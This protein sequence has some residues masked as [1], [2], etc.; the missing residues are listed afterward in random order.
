MN[1]VEMEE[2][3]NVIIGGDSQPLHDGD[4]QPSSLLP[5]ITGGDFQQ[6]IPINDIQSTNAFEDSAA[7]KEYSIDAQKLIKKKDEK[8]EEASTEDCKEEEREERGR[9]TSE[10]DVGNSRGEDE[11]RSWEREE[12]KGGR[13]R[14]R[15][16][17]EE[18]TSW[19][20]DGT[21]DNESE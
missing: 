15:E 7:T 17:R 9:W 18:S 4:S 1:P 21:Y 10:R 13:S 11:R 14:M 6:L 16:D 12:H 8:P 3:A 20:R 2:T 5:D 19:K